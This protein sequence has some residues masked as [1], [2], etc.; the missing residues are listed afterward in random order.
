MSGQARLP[1][2]RARDVGDVIITAE[3]ARRPSRPPDH[4]AENLALRG[5]A[6]TMASEPGLLLQGLAE[7]AMALTR[8]G[9]AGI[10]LL[11]H[12]GPQGVFR[13]VAASGAFSPHRGGTLPAGA[14]PCSEAL[15]RD[16]VLLMREPGRVYPACFEVGPDIHEAL[17]APF[18][19]D[20][21]PAGVLWA[22]RHDRDAGFEREDARLLENLAR[23]AAAA[24]GM[25]RAL[26]GS[27]AADERSRTEL[28]ARLADA[29][30]LQRLSA[31]LVRKQE[32]GALHE[33]S[34]AAAMALMRAD[35]ASLQVLEPGGERLLLLASRNL[36]PLSVAHWQLVDAGDASACG[37]SLRAHARFVVEDCETDPVLA[38]TGDL[39]EFRRSGIRAAQS[40]PLVARSG[41][42]VGLISTHW[43]APWRLVEADLRLLD[44]LARQLA[45]LI[46]SAATE[47]TLREGE[48]RQALLLRLSDALRATGDPAEI[49][50]TAMRMLGEHLG[51]ARTYYFDVRRDEHGWV[52]V[53]ESTFQRD[54]AQPSMVGSHSLRG[55][56][57]WMFEG[58]ARGEA[59]AVADVTAI[60]ALTPAEVGSYLAL[61]VAAFINVPLLK[62]G[63]Y[64]AGIGAHD[65]APRAWTAGEIG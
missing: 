9:S 44:V 21:R 54:P 61:G 34:L 29:E 46:E 3:L 31:G 48:E 7:A 59:I 52:H 41:R 18:H 58:F 26:Q 42:P 20:G 25:A 22:V 15:A 6:G 5:L 8:A 56:G 60:P 30:L 1:A 63:E 14:S 2:G 39:A 10:S 62:Y 19:A 55:F 27:R 4:E 35:A 40:T 53:I 32:P 49:E 51:L 38:G 64:S 12:D 45:D 13:W 37:Q 23:F 57:T 17:Y 33:Q 43:R 16:E 36:H 47:A 65:T 28:A 50:R 11:E 24:H